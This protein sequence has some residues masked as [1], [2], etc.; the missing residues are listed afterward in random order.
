MGIKITDRFLNLLQQVDKMEDRPWAV[1]RE[2]FYFNKTF[3]EDMGRRLTSNWDEIGGKQRLIEY[4]V[5]II[6]LALSFYSSSLI[7]V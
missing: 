4:V 1:L 2:K 3:T 6:R 7:Q 5:L